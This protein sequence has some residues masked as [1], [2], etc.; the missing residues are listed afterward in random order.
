ITDPGS[1]LD[2]L[3]KAL[4]FRAKFL[5]DPNIGGRYSALSYFGLVPAGLIGVDL[6]T[7]LDRA[8]AMAETC[9]ADHPTAQNPGAILGAVMGELAQQGRDKITLITSPTLTSFGDWVEQ[10]IAES[11]G[12]EGKGILPVVGEPVGSPGDYGPDRLF[13]YLQLAGD[14]THD[15]AVAALE[16]AGYPVVRVPL[17]DRYDLGAQYFLWELATAVASV[18]LEINP[19]DQPNVESAKVQARKMVTEY[20]EKGKLP[21]LTPALESDG[22]AV[23]GDVEADSVGAALRAFIDQGESRAYIAVMA[24]IQPTT[25]TDAALL[26]LCTHLRAATHFAVTT[27]YGPRFLHSTGQ[28][29]KGD[30]G[31]GLFIQITADA[32]QDVAIPDK[33]GESASAMSFDVLK[34]AQ[35]LG[36]RQALIEANRRVIRF[37]LGSDTVGGLKTLIQ[38]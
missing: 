32:P 10:L 18:H 2:A 1:K 12:K 24:Y 4:D 27:G 8:M 3:A 34:L 11:T 5:S 30:G 22:I 9:S 14:I 21:T 16:A 33:P 6:N 23:Y 35:A 20:H 26:E 17:A 19:F 25:E 7:L 31:N 38:A 36:D 28:L 29:H 13:A 37:H 15:A